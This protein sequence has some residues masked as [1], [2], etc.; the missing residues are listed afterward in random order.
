MAAPA[1]CTRK[2]SSSVST[3]WPVVRHPAQS[4]SEH[5]SNTLASEIGVSQY[6]NCIDGCFNRCRATR[7]KAAILW[8]VGRRTTKKTGS[9]LH[10]KPVHRQAVDSCCSLSVCGHLAR[11]QLATLGHVLCFP[12]N[13]DNWACASSEHDTSLLTPL[14]GKLKGVCNRVHDLYQACWHSDGLSI[15]P[16]SNTNLLWDVYLSR[17]MTFGAPPSSVSS[18]VVM[19][20]VH[21]I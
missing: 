5:P 15:S 6:S 14:D 13:G 1:S 7:F 2:R 11:V 18:R 12:H 17:L 21:Q 16:C 9:E 10:M 20:W 8:T 4:E 3:C 19:L